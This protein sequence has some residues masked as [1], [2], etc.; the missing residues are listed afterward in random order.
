M[1]IESTDE[2]AAALLRRV[3][4]QCGIEHLDAALREHERA[5]F[6]LLKAVDAAA[7]HDTD[8]FVTLIV[9]LRDQSFD[10]GG[11]EATAP[12]E[13]VFRALL[14]RVKTITS[15]QIHDHVHAMGEEVF[16]LERMLPEQSTHLRQT[17]EA[18]L[19]D[20]HCTLSGQPPFQSVGIIRN[21]HTDGDSKDGERPS[22]T[23]IV[24]MEPRYMLTA[25]PL[26]GAPAM[27]YQV[28]RIGGAGFRRIIPE[29]MSIPTLLDWR[30]YQRGNRMELRDQKGTVW[31]RAQT[32]LPP[33]W[34]QAAATSKRVL[35]L[36][37]FGFMLQEPAERRPAFASPQAFAEHFHTVASSGLLT[38]AFVA[39]DGA[40]PP[41]RARRQQDRKPRKR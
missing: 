16:D 39:W 19:A 12:W 28:H 10:A 17:A 33:R 31:A 25:M 9:E 40:R 21:P 13:Q 2:T 7:H 18:A 22:R 23:P 3:L 27:E 29:A 24:L 20:V 30:L 11:I 14:E 37:G 41:K 1:W 32:S 34:L 8:D 5:R 4:T 26:T 38:A 36:Y 15:K 35:V 6:T